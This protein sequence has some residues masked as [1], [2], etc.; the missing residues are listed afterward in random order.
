MLYPQNNAFRQFIDLS[1]FWDFRFAHDGDEWS[2]GFTGGQPIAVPASWN[3]IFADDRDNLGPA[4]YQTRF[5]LPWGWSD[6]RICLRF[7]SVGYLAQ[8]WL[9]GEYL[10]GHEGG[11]LPF[12]FDIT[13]K[14]RAEA[15]LLVVRVDGRMQPNH[16]P[17][18]NV[19]QR[20]PLD[21]FSE[22]RRYPDTTYD[23][24]PFCGIQRPVLLCAVPHD[25]IEDITVTTDIEGSTG[26]VRVQTRISGE[27]QAALR[28]QGAAFN[29]PISNGSAELRVANAQ[30][31]GIGQPNLYE[32]T[33]EQTDGATVT[34]R[35]TLDVGIRTVRVV[36]DQLLLNG[37]PVY[38][39]GFGRHEDSVINGRGYQPAM[40]IKDYSLMQWIGAN[41]FRTSHYPYSEQQMKLADQLGVLIIDE[42]PAVGLYF[43]AE[44]LERRLALCQQQLNELMAR[45]KNHPSVIMWSI[46]NEPHSHREGHQAFFRALYD[47]AKAYDSTRPVT[48]VSHI[49]LNETSFEFLDVICYNRYRG[50]YQQPGQIAEGVAAL[51]KELDALHAR[52]R[53]PIILSEFGADAVP[54]MHSYPAEMFSEE[55]QV[56]YLER[57]LHMLRTR[58][59]MIGEHVWNMCD[60]KTPQSIRRVAGLNFK[61]VF[62]RDRRPKMAAFKLRE[63]WNGKARE[64]A[65]GVITMSVSTGAGEAS[66]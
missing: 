57:H 6:K 53:K 35:Y 21:M 8:V 46:A 30:L 45:D 31:W 7:G 50:W 20:D 5:A 63:L 4:F 65:N 59:Y 58:P 28:G 33:I 48:L 1:G 18:G 61:G 12:T 26:V 39:R 44:G 36:G 9:N 66:V 40:M 42:I 22:H 17:P 52:Y 60:F 55:Y 19:T 29:A 51:A 25:G 3:E 34:D 41:S 15:N 54:G 49:G 64:S 38:L 23:F 11:H 14:A 2:G 43:R 24:Y 13:D 37:V 32:L 10:G 62:T 47:Q 56:E 27:G 16:V